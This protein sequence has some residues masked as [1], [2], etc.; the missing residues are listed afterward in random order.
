MSC[1]AAKANTIMENEAESKIS[2]PNIYNDSHEIIP[3]DLE[4]SSKLLVV[5]AERN[6]FAI[7]DCVTGKAIAVK[8]YLNS[9]DETGISLYRR[10]YKSNPTLILTEAEET[11]SMVSLLLR[12]G[13]K[14]TGNQC[15]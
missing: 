7:S 13:V 8:R 15:Y 2:D 12:H 6:I 9:S 1:H 5:K 3:I 14:V 11:L 4:D 10:D